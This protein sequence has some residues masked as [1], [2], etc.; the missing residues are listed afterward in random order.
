MECK[1]LTANFCP[2]LVLRADYAAR[3]SWF[4]AT[5][6]IAIEAGVAMALRYGVDHLSKGAV[7]TADGDSDEDVLDM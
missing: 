1:H 4:R 5:V 7:G 2:P 6:S 3:I